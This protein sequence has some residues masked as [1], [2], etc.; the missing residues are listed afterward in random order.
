MKTLEEGQKNEERTQKDV[1]SRPF[2]L[3]VSRRHESHFHA[4][5]S[6]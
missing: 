5:G 1:G 3:P 4:F 6:S 2:V